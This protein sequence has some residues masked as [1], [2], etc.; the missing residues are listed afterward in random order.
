LTPAAARWLTRAAVV[1]AALAGLS[2]A[3]RRR[4]P[5]VRPEAP[6][7][8]GFVPTPRPP[9]RRPLPTAPLALDWS[10]ADRPA[11]GVEVIELQPGD[12]A[13]LFPG[14]VAVLEADL[15]RGDGALFESTR[16]QDGPVRWLVGER[17]LPPGL[18][19]ALLGLRAGGARVA[20]IEP[21]EGFGGAGVPGRIPPGVGLQ[22]ELELVAV[23][24]P[25]GRAPTDPGTP[26]PGDGPAWREGDGATLDYALWSTA[27]PDAPLDAS[28]LRWYPHPIRPG[29]PVAPLFVRAL[30]GLRPGGRRVVRAP[31]EEVFGADGRPPLAP[32]G[33]TVLLQVDLRSVHPAR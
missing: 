28:V 9:P 22:V 29:E 4:D 17:A 5:P 19:A 6:P 12:G 14:N 21:D 3:T 30:D 25:P 7:A 10:D 32:P 13:P 20:W 8:R 1:A 11:P 27:D 15:W 31:A 2:L 23:I 16:E 26:R 33:A 18:E 24:V